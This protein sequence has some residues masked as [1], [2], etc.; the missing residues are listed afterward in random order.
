VAWGDYD[1]DGD[2]DLAVSNG[3]LNNVQNAFYI[4]NGDGTFTY[5]AQFGYG[6]SLTVAWGDYDNDG[7]LD[8]ALGNFKQQQ[9]YLYVNNGN[10][11]FTQELQFGAGSTESLS[12]GDYDDDGDLDV[13]VANNG[14]N[15]LFVN[16]E[17]DNDFLRL[18]LEGHGYDQGAGY[19][20]RDG[21]GAKV[22]IYASGCLGN[23][24]SL[25]G[26]R[27]I[28]ANGGCCGQ[29]SLDAEFGMEGIAGVDVLVKWP[30]SKGEHLE[31]CWPGLSPT[32]RLTLHEGQ[33]IPYA[34]CAP[35]ETTLSASAG[36]A[37]D[38][39]LFGGLGCANR[40]YLLLGGI[41]GIDP[42]T[43]LPGGYATLPVNLDIFTYNVLLPLINSPVFSNFMGVLDAQGKSTAQ[44]SWSGPV[45]PPSAIGI[46]MCYAFCC[47][48]P[49]DFVSNPVVIEIV[50]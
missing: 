11:T 36:G 9:N 15:K 45:L 5:Q 27:E 28:E 44:L 16:T 46:R 23:E 40:Q 49:Y 32:Q 19:S 1:N 22:H 33:G 41:T 18:H 3:F 31:E 47:N 26:Y 7:D 35:N 34:L 21:I 6:Y 42:G 25:L 4:N 43:P 24:N 14:Q 13:A 48:R 39:D 38:F 12:W 37:V 8:A 30:G 10:G 2:L 50:Q 29:D 17:N 20:T